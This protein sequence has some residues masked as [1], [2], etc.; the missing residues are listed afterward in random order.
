MFSY[1]RVTPRIEA[2]YRLPRGL[3]ASGLFKKFKLRHR[4][5]Y[6]K[7]YFILIKEVKILTFSSVKFCFGL[8]ASAKINFCYFFEIHWVGAL[9]SKLD[10]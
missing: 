1:K 6:R 5:A 7:K 8:L 9:C 2:G 10:T 4:I 3:K